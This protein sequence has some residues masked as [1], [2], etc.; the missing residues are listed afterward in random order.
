MRLEGDSKEIFLVNFEDRADTWQG[1][2]PTVSK[3][4][5]VHK[6]VAS[7]TTSG[8]E[9]TLWAPRENASDM[10]LES[11]PF[12]V[13]SNLG[14]QNPDSSLPDCDIISGC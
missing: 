2:Q 7:A 4:R 1:M 14:M 11:Q 10:T 8:A 13:P 9:K 3:R 5:L 12:E 6:E